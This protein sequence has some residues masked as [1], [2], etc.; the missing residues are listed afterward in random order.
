ML[1]LACVSVLRLPAEQSLPMSPHGQ[2]WLKP[3]PEFR[4][5]SLTATGTVFRLADS[6]NLKL[7]RYAANAGQ[8][9]PTPLVVELPA[10]EWEPEVTNSVTFAVVL[11]LAGTFDEPRDESMRIEM[12]DS[13]KVAALSFSG[14]YEPARIAARLKELRD[15]LAANGQVVVGKPRLLLYHYRAFRPDFAKHAELQ[16]PVR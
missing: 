2:V 13:S 11:P 6:A 4:V 3:V 1:L 12:R 15:W 9:R 7:C 8:E 16:V 10:L 5:V 14:A